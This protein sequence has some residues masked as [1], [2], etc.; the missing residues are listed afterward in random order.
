MQDMLMLEWAVLMQMQIS[1]I[2]QV[3]VEISFI[4]Q[5]DA[6]DWECGWSFKIGKEEIIIVFEADYC[7]V[8]NSR[9]QGKDTPVAGKFIWF[10]FD[11]A[12][13]K[14]IGSYW[15]PQVMECLRKHAPF[16]GTNLPV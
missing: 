11:T 7:A 5:E 3:P 4:S 9:F 1:D 2:V 8:T 6:V 13:T 12:G 14:K 15:L 10:E 16:D